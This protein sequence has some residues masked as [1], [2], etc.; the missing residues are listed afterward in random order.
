MTFTL[1][2][3]AVTEILNKVVAEKGADYVYPRAVASDAYKAG[4]MYSEVDDSGEFAPSCIVGHVVA[5]LDL[6]SFRE[7]AHMEN[8]EGSSFDAP[9]LFQGRDPLLQTDDVLIPR[10]LSEAQ[11]AQDRGL[12]WGFALSQYELVMSGATDGEANSRLQ[13]AV[14]E[15]QAAK[16]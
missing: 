1:K 3:N 4:C 14:A 12:T 6:D 2:T 13:A 16:N 7:I 8:N 5:A 10:A 9:E 15:L 11:R